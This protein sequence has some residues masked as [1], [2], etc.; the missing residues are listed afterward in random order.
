MSDKG[1]SCGRESER[2]R[3]RERQRE[4]ERERESAAKYGSFCFV[5][6]EWTLCICTALKKIMPYNNSEYEPLPAPQSTPPISQPPP[7]SSISQNEIF[8]PGPPHSISVPMQ[9]ASTSSASA[10]TS[11]AI[12]VS[13]H[14][15][16]V[17]AVATAYAT[18]A[19]ASASVS[20]KYNH[21][22][23]LQRA[24]KLIAADLIFAGDN[25]NNLP[26]Q[27]PPPSPSTSLPQLPPLSLTPS[28][29]FSLVFQVSVDVTPPP[30]VDRSD[31]N[32]YSRSIVPHHHHRH[33]QQQQQPPP[34]SQPPQHKQHKYGSKISSKSNISASTIKI[35]I[36]TR[37]PKNILIS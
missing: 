5:L 33:P 4:R 17:T 32:Q 31:L 11:A 27:Q 21:Q 36:N 2:E 10:T 1:G 24:S 20:A 13:T 23:Q 30:P 15:T 16:S 18:A 25:N 3:Q 29:V 37:K 19:A 35:Y 8:I 6:F 7:A 34:A 28:P 26:L 12:S 9:S 14:T 22:K